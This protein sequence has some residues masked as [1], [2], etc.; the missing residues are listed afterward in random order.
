V[1]NG[2]CDSGLHF[3]SLP[4]HPVSGLRN[5]LLRDQP[6]RATAEESPERTALKFNF[7]IAT[8]DFISFCE[9]SAGLR[10]SDAWLC[11][12]WQLYQYIKGLPPNGVCHHDL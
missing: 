6:S 7:P 8:E 9:H 1:V 4:F 10:D 5:T 2:L 12:I 11:V 3:P